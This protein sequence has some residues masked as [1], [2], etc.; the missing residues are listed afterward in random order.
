MKKKSGSPRDYEVFEKELLPH[1][2]N[3]Y[4]YACKSIKDPDLAKDVLQDTYA[5]AF[6]YIDSYE[7]GTNGL[8]WVFRI[9]KSTLVNNIRRGKSRGRD[10]LINYEDAETLGLLSNYSKIG[11]Y[12]ESGT[13]SKGASDK[14]VTAF[15][16]LS[17]KHKTVMILSELYGYNYSEISKILDIPKGTIMSRLHR[18]KKALRGKLIE[19]GNDD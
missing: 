9:L 12:Y 2:R 16:T 6:Q 4:Y 8:A 15:N 19:L 11:S 5:R 10:D 17:V 3:L 1:Y 7:P 18:A 13:V 14:L